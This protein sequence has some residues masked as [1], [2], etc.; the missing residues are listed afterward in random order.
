LINYYA[1]YFTW[2]V[3]GEKIGRRKSRGSERRNTNSHLAAHG[4]LEK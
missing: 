2:V 3:G 1:E 4:D